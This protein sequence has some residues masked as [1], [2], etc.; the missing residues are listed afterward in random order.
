MQQLHAIF[1]TASA[2]GASADTRT[3]DR[4]VML[5]FKAAVVRALPIVRACIFHAEPQLR[6]PYLELSFRRHGRLASVDTTAQLRRFLHEAH[7]RPELVVKIRD[8]AV[9]CER[10][11]RAAMDGGRGAPGHGPGAPGTEHRDVPPKSAHAS[12][13]R[14][15]GRRICKCYLCSERIHEILA[16]RADCATYTER[17]IRGMRHA[18]MAYR[19]PPAHIGAGRVSAM[20]AAHSDR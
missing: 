18:V 10:P 20:E 19:E 6:A 2:A 17:F 1:G 7:P 12:T 9:K 15:T 16:A 3:R 13:W 11:P 14:N 4:D 8:A 5:Q